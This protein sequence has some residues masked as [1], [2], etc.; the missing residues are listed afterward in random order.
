MSK[1]FI[2]FDYEDSAS[3]STIVNWKNQKIGEDISFS[4][5]DGIDHASKGEK[6]IRKILRE[7]I[8]DCQVVFVLVGNNTHNRPWVDFEVHHA[9]CQQ[10]K[11]IW[12]QLPKTAGSPPKE[13]IKVKPI[14]FD[15]E[16]IRQAI[17][18]G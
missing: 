6:F 13:I 7:K 4:F 17:R 10:K 15:I 16:E 3:K 9:K 5:E 12:T 11:V 1:V 8:N 2:S 18:I 14:P